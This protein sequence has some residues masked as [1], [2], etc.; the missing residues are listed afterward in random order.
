[1]GPEISIDYLKQRR[2]RLSQKIAADPELVQRAMMYLRIT[3]EV[4][5]PDSHAPAL[6]D[7][8]FLE[9][10]RLVDVM[11]VLVDHD[12]AR[13]LN[14]LDPSAEP[15]HA[16]LQ[17]L[18]N[19]FLARGEL[20][21]PT[22]LPWLWRD[23]QPPIDHDPA[24]MDFIVDLLVELGLLTRLSIADQLLLPMRLPD[25][26]EALAA[27]ASR[28]QFTSFL[29]S[30]EDGVAVNAVRVGLEEAIASI[31]Q[32]G[33][34]LAEELAEGLRI[35]F[36]KADSIIPAG[37]SCDAN[38]LNRDEIAA[39]NLY[40]QENTHSSPDEKANLYRPLNSALRSN[41]LRRS[42]RT[43]NISGCCSGLC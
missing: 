22:L 9:P 11:K 15:V 39:V 28:S 8:V 2:C 5:F 35:A 1:M 36:S 18:G 26:R 33:T 25:R 31:V 42:G 13:R 12:L 6:R 7:R 14:Q 20:D 10:Q 43:G 24:Q 41:N 3:G 17:D 34:M 19:R 32:T 38:E 16:R 37:A 4:L 40:T 29:A 23:L 27:S 21:R 30:M